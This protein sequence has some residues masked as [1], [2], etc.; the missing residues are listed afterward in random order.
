MLT[1]YTTQPLL[2]GHVANLFTVEFEGSGNDCLRMTYNIR[3]EEDG[4]LDIILWNVATQSE[5]LLET[6][7]A[8]R[9]PE[10]DS[11]LFVTITG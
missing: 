10:V 11:L 8:P 4:T 7:A 5:T 3:S 6:L 9:S 2:P 1:F